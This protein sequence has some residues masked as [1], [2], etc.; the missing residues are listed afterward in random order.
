MVYKSVGGSVP[1]HSEAKKQRAIWCT[2]D[3]WL[4]FDAIAKEF[5]LSKSELLEMIGQGRLKVVK[6]D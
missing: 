6:P 1:R 3:S 4:N 5:M 2:D